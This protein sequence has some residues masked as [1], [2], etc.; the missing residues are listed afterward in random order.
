MTFLLVMLFGGVGAVVRF[1]AEYVTR[2]H[3]PTQRPWATVAVNALGA[4]VVGWAT[5]ALAGPSDAHVR[6]VV[7]TGFCGGLT[8]FSSALAIPAL[9]QREH[10]WR[11]GLALVLAAPMLAGGAFAVGLAL[12]H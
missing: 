6:D 8:T 7:I 2:E 3:H 5:A 10:H 11:Y 4:L 1:T 12:G 9:L